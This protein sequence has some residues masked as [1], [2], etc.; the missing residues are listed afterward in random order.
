M[1]LFGISDLHLSSKVNKPMDVFGGVWE[2]Y[3]EK[4]KT[5]WEKTVGE[6]DTVIVPGDISWATYMDEA[7]DDFVFL[8]KLK[9]RKLILKGNHDY[10]FETAAKLENRLKELDI[11]NI[12]LIHNGF[13]VYENTAI[14]GTKGGDVTRPP[15]SENG[16][17]LEN[18]EAMRLERSILAA[19]NEGFNDIIAFLHYPPVLKYGKYN[20][21]PF[22]N[23][24]KKYEIKKCFYGHLHSKA[25]KIALCEQF[26]GTEYQLISADFINF[27]PFLIKM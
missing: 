23:I 14:C 12:S 3:M 7:T 25:H 15:S 27:S 16:K 5:N 21:N 6:N 2:N 19:K 18:R 9:G 17:K 1:S 13:G 4:I 8:S 20:D 11:N 10:W 24:L 26:N 22:T